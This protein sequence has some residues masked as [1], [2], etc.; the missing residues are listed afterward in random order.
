MADSVKS[1]NRTPILRSL[2]FKVLLVAASLLVA[3]LAFAFAWG[4][5]EQH[6]ETALRS[7]VNDAATDAATV[8]SRPNSTSAEAR[9]DSVARNHGV[10]LRWVT[11]DSQ[12]RL[13]ADHQR[14]S[15]ALHDLSETL[16]GDDRSPSFQA[17]DDSLGHVAFRPETLGASRGETVTGCRTSVGSKLLVC[18]SVKMLSDGEFLHVQQTSRRAL[19]ALYDSRFQLIRIVLLLLPV[20]LALAWWTAGYVVRPLEALREEAMRKAASAR[21][22]GTLSLRG[23]DEV[24]DLSRAFNALLSNL[25]DRRRDNEHFV[26]DLVHEFKTPV[27]TVSACSETLASGGVDDARAARLSRMLQEASARLDVL[28]TQFLELARTQAGMAGENRTYVDLSALAQGVVAAQALRHP[29]LAF[30][31]SCDGSPRVAGVEVRL[32]SLL[33]NLLD[34]AACFAAQRVTVRAFVEGSEV[35]VEVADDGP[36]LAPDDLPRVFDRFF[37]TRERSKGSGLGLALVR[38][39]AEAHGGS[40]TA[41]SVPA[42]GAVFVVRLPSGDR[43][44]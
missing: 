9:L 22:E 6:V 43:P 30:E 40:V 11:A 7:N 42:Q 37:T 34:N 16:L 41:S 26:A 28:V 15:D 29:H 38:A 21:P 25:D 39:V 20:A 17:F 44:P 8:L 23:N 10:R 33:R 35:I 3:P 32:E 14:Q 27:S 36:G 18:H 5:A 4:L 19:R 31:V 1:G 13:D 2:R 24:G 12:V